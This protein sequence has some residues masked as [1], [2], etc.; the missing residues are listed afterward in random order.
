MSAKIAFYLHRKTILMA[1]KLI[2]P[3]NLE[4]RAIYESLAPQLSSLICGELDSVANMANFAAALKEAFGFFWV[5]FYVVKD[6][7][8]ILGPFQGPVACTRIPFNKG[9][10]GHSYSIGKTVVVP[11]VDAFPGH[12]ACSSESKSEIVV[13]VYNNSKEIVAVLDID[14]NRNDDFD[15]VDTHFLEELVQLLKSSFDSIE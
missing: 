4:R 1:E 14:S 2:L 13:P 3:S 12:I 8:L 10:C 6:G 11:D 7:Q 9:V 15:E 5:G